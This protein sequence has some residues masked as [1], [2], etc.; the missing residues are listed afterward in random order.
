MTWIKKASKIKQEEEENEKYL[1]EKGG[2]A[3]LM[4]DGQILKRQ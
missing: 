2:S 1:I 3:E 4:V